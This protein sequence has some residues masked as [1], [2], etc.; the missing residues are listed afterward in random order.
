MS[1]ARRWH[2]IPTGCAPWGR[3]QTERRTWT[4][5]RDQKS[6]KIE[7][8][9]VTASHPFRHGPL[10]SISRFPFELPGVPFL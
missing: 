4:V 9:P 6:E 7:D 2:I 5:L 8:S 10:M 3:F 1:S